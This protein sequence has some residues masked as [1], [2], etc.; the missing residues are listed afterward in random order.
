MFSRRATGH[1]LP[2]RDEIVAVSHG[3]LGETELLVAAATLHDIGY[4]SQ[5]AHTGFHPTCWTERC[6]CAHSGTHRGWSTWS[7]TTPKP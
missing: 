5:I 1:A 3:L 4:A 2:S 7:P 6:S